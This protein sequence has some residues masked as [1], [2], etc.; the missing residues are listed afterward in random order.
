MVYKIINSKYRVFF[1]TFFLTLLIMVIGFSL[2]F[3]AEY[4]RTNAVIEKYK[5]YE[6]KSLDLKLQNY[7]YQ[8]MDR[9][10][11][12]EAIKQ[13]FIFADDL[14]LDGLKLEQYEEQNQISDDILFEKRRYVLLKTELWLNSIILKEKCGDVFDT[15]VYIYSADPSSNVKVAEQKVLSNILKDV[16]KDYG[17]DIILIPIAG[18]L[19]H[20]TQEED[21]TIGIIDMQLR[22][23][24]ISNLPSII[25]NEKEVLEGFHTVE[26]I[27]SHLTNRT[28]NSSTTV[29]KPSTK[30]INSS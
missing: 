19:K 21:A 29:K 2:G 9:A 14:Y 8:I 23:Y 15:V 20:V 28:A 24:N 12:Q 3:Y 4:Y 6:S 1:D 30:R 13:N 7:Y 11:C 25:I 22:I 18:D 27:E 26:D 17:N 5:A 16:K 10:S